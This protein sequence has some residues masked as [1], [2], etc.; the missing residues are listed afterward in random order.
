LEHQVV[1]ITELT[2]QLDME[3]ID[4]VSTAGLEARYL[5]GSDVF[6]KFDPHGRVQGVACANS[7][8]E[9]CLLYL[10]VVREEYRLMGTGSAVVNHVLGYYSQ[11][12]KQ[13]YALVDDMEGFFQR[14]GFRFISMNDIPEVI[15]NFERFDQLVSPRT[16]AMVL[17]ISSGWTIT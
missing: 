3:V 2:P 10:V 8:G 1:K 9:Y 14:F 6:V 17:N 7:F 16:Y 11:R 12:C 15:S 5:P 4:L 13:A